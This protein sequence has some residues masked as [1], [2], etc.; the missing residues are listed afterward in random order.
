VLA[1]G[2]GWLALSFAVGGVSRALLPEPAAPAVQTPAL[3]LTMLALA[4]LAVAF[5]V[6]IA[7]LLTE[8]GLLFRTFTQRM[9]QRIVPIFSF[10]VV[11]CFAVVVFASLY[12]V[13]D[14]FSGRPNFT[15]TGAIRAI[16]FPEALYFSFITLSTIGYGDI[17]P[18]TAPARLLVVGEIIFGVV[19]MLFAFAEIA[20]YDPHAGERDRTAG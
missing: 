14:R 9:A 5:A 3:L 7:V 17:T 18:V 1:R 10:V 11:F 15:V 4:A 19:L 13:L 16:T 20:A 2:L 8:T 6:D 12:A